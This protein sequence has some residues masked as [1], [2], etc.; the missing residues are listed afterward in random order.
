[1]TAPT[2]IDGNPRPSPLSPRPYKFPRFERVTLD[3]GLELVVAPVHK[4]PLVTVVALVD[5]GALSDPT[6][7][8]GL[9]LITARALAEGTER[10][11]GA[12]LAER[13]ELLGTAFDA[14]ADWDAATAGLTVVSERLPEAL[15]LFAEVITLPAF[16]EREIERIKA[17]RLADLLQLR[18]EPRGLADEMFARFVYVPESRYARPD[19]G[20]AESVGALT[21]DEI[22]ASYRAR[23][24]PQGSTLIV[25]GD[26]TVE[27]A[28]QLV[29]DAFG[30]W[31]GKGA[32]PATTVDR[33]ATTQR[34]IHIVTK[35]DAPQSE[36]R[37]GHPG[38][39]RRHPDYYAV[40][41]MNMVLGGL[42]NSRINLNLREAHAYTYGAFSSFDWRRGAGPF[43]V[44]TAVKSDVTDA[45]AAEVIK[46]IDR[47]RGEEIA[48]DEL[49][50]ATSY[51]D[52][53]FPIRY[54][55]TAAIANALATLV[56]YGLPEDYFDT[57]RD[58]IRAVQR[59][60]VRR[61]AET[62]LHPEQMQIVVVGDPG[63]VRA[64][65]ESLGIGP[66]TVYDAEGRPV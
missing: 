43:E 62:H 14:S 51:L 6:G 4:L 63:V 52:G 46:E 15:A 18:T 30:G 64:P 38:I 32:T 8:E 37:I 61:V 66:V 56:L 34:R 25:V 12:T 24:R 54:E 47:I 55:T 41:V 53:V 7:R 40:V 29:N 45:A 35:E 31:R 17:E 57:Y 9:A 59:G 58:R 27:R 21:R 2:T 20:D 3:T 65:M 48:D 22:V 23:Y 16:P 11:D 10:S 1:M 13:F 39:P 60:E 44:S 28:V 49:S 50:L 19:G 5:A 36:L 33:P 42:F 26:V